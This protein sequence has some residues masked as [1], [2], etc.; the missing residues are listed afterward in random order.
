LY[1]RIIVFTNSHS[2]LFLELKKYIPVLWEYRVKQLKMEGIR[3]RI[4]ISIFMYST[5]IGVCVEYRAHEQ[6]LYDVVI[7][8]SILAAA[9]QWVLLSIL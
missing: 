8:Y 7:Y 6:F 4:P 5:Q 3:F 1:V 2:L 9:C